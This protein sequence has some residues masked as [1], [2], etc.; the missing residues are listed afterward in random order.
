MRRWS[1]LV[2]SDLYGLR[3]DDSDSDFLTVITCE[4]ALAVDS[5][6]CNAG[7]CSE[8]AGGHEAVL[9]PND[10]VKSTLSGWKW[11]WEAWVKP[12]Q[13]EDQAQGWQQCRDRLVKS[14][15]FQRVSY[16]TYVKYR[17]RYLPETEVHASLDHLPDYKDWKLKS[18]WYHKVGYYLCLNAWFVSSW[19]RVE[20]VDPDLRSILIDLKRGRLDRD[21]WKHVYEDLDRDALY[22]GSFAKI[23]ETALLSWRDDV[24]GE[25]YVA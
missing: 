5:L 11:A 1:F 2:G 4:D 13:D 10:L 19:P 20:I 7:P 24:L 23:D 9:S 6:R 18:G 14:N 22:S 25:T 16:S 15:L 21:A 17:E 12:P 8:I 3:D